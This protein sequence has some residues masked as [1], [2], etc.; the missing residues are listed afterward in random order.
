MPSYLSRRRK[1]LSKTRHA[2]DWLLTYADT[3]T[4]L[5][6]FFVVFA[7]AGHHPKKEVVVPAPPPVSVSVPVTPLPAPAVKEAVPPATPD[8]QP[9]APYPP[10][11][12]ES[13]AEDPPAPQTPPQ[14]AA[15]VQTE[16]ADGARILSFELS[17]T[18]MFDSGSAEIKPG[19]EETLAALADKL[20][21]PSYADYLVTVEGHT[22]DSPVQTAQFPS[23]WELSTARAA[24]VV[25]FFVGHGV[26]AE[27][28]RVAGYA[29]TYPK[30]PNRDEK[31]APILANQ[32]QNRRVVVRLEKVLSL[33]EKN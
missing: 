14:D 19:A 10:L 11:S 30:V 26:R 31:G 28:L 4:L 29:D 27:K 2:D 6:C 25:R 33:P 18:A 22:D 8:A 15:A 12:L 13:H 9:D 17:S 1:S 5:F 24:A 16:G 20:K 23:N 3:I 21:D 7:V 32:A